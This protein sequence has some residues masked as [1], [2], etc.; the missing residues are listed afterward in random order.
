MKSIIKGCLASVLLISVSLANAE[1]PVISEARI[2][3]PPPG[4][5][6]AAAYFTIRN[7]SDEPLEITGASSEAIANISIHLSAIADDVAKMTRQD[8][9]TIEAG[10]SLEFKHGSYHLMLMGLTAPL[11]PGSML[12][13][14]I[15]TSA[16]VIPIMIPIITP[17]EASSMKSH[18]INHENMDTSK[19]MDKN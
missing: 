13:F 5:K 19:S 12:A 7:N 3:Q 6:V 10:S 14:E 15:D 18:S 1:P 9:V 8:S 17:D 11:A 2:I 4:A 16:G